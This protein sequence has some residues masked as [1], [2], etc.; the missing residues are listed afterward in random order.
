[1]SASEFEMLSVFSCFLSSFS[2]RV[3]QIAFSD[4]SRVVK[5]NHGNM[6]KEY[7]IIYDRHNRKFMKVGAGIEGSAIFEEELR[8]HIH[9]YNLTK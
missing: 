6:Y 5:K 4:I 3:R 9:T 2:P 1:M 8:K 7:W